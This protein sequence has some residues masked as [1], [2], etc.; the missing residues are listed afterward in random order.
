MLFKKKKETEAV[1]TK[2]VETPAAAPAAKAPA[3]QEEE[4]AA[5]ISL[6]LSMY[7]A[8]VHEYESMVLTMQ[9]VMRPYSPWSSKLYGLR[10]NPR[11]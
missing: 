9:K 2:T 10:K 7:L 6:A 8:D 3:S 1:E 11:Y 4:V 5:A